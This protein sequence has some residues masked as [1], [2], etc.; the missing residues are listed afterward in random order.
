G[1]VLS[2]GFIDIHNHSAG[3]LAGDTAAE[4]QV[5][6]GITTIVLGPDGSSPWPI[7]D[8]LAE[9]RR[10]PS[11]LNVA[12]MVGHATV[13]RMVMG[14]DFRR[15]ARADEVEQM[16]QLVEQGMREGAVGLSTGLEYEVGSYSETS[17]IVELAKAASRHGGIYMS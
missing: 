9:R 16:A 11:S 2:P 15:P 10:A 5:A 13:R 4:S 17:E 12:V 3:E 6:Q 1:L 8:Y 7:G 14:D